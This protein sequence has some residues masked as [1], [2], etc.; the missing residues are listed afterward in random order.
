MVYLYSKTTAEKLK[1]RKTATVEN[2]ASTPVRPIIDYNQRLKLTKNKLDSATTER[3]QRKLVRVIHKQFYDH[4]YDLLGN[5][6]QMRL[7]DQSSPNANAW[8]F[9]SYNVFGRTRIA[10]DSFRVL[11][12]RRLGYRFRTLFRTKCHVR[13]SHQIICG[14]SVD[15]YGQHITESCKSLSTKRHD[16][17]KLEIGKICRELGFLVETEQSCYQKTADGDARPADLLIHEWW[18]GVSV[19]LDVTVVSSIGTKALRDNQN[20]NIA[21]AVSRAEKEKLKCYQ[22][23]I[24]EEQQLAIRYIPFAISTFGNFGF[25][26]RDFMTQL[27]SHASRISMQSTYVVH[28]RLHQRILAVVFA[29]M[30]K[31]LSSHPKIV[32]R[33]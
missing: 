1:N 22:Q 7:L 2:K 33:Y 14:S 27:V 23:L 21:Y 6:D 31:S 5:R 4:L 19:A 17:L 12:L 20:Q 26:A 15:E 29:F 32:P 10:P 28:R 24:T 25:R 18:P 13:N 3:D 9:P 11:L 16:A 30:G 8:L